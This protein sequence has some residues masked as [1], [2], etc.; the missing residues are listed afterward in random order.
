MILKR[1]RVRFEKKN[2]IYFISYASF[3]V[4]H[5]VGINIHVAEGHSGLQTHISS[6][7]KVC[8]SYVT[9]S[10]LMGRQKIVDYYSLYCT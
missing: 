6:C 9:N 2:R 8:F 10:Y 5:F 4:W 3:E 1:Q 7:Y